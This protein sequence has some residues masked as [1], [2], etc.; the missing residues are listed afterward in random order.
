MTAVER[1]PPGTISWFDL[2]TPDAD[3]ARAF[4]QGLFG[5]TYQIGPAETGHYTICQVRGLPA[6][7]LGPLP[8]GACFPS[9]WN[10][11]FA[12]AE[13]D[14]VAARIKAER[15]QVAMGP[16]DVME[17]GRLAFCMDPTG[18][19]VG[20]WQPKRHVG[21]QIVDEP[22]AMA[23]AELLTRDPVAA[24]A[25]YTRVFGLEARKLDAPG[26]DYTTLH[27]GAKTVGGIMQMGDHYPAATPPH[28]MA[29]F[30]VAD[31]DAAVHRA[32][33]LGGRVIAPAFD[34]P[35]GR[36]AV[37]GDSTGA[38]FSVITLASAS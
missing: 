34:S 18:A 10:I 24:S 21:A 8:P 19:A 1:H 9:A 14:P 15:G 36:I 37:L 32:T 4:Y 25:F 3:R 6:A 29:Y 35:H 23:W 22:G 31:T 7:G 5:W 2:M 11:Y 27:L 33:D 13:I 17:E 26:L 28:W 12:V 16:M 20:L 38:V 30:A